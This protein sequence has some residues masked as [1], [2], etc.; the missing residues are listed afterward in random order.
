VAVFDCSNLLV[1]WFTI[2]VRSH[3]YTRP[4]GSASARLCVD[5]NLVGIDITV[6]EEVISSEE[7]L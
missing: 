6:W 2:L 5:T 4:T 3:I 1:V 7:A